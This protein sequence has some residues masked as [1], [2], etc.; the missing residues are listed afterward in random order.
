MT[1]SIVTSNF[2]ICAFLY[3]LFFSYFQG[4]LVFVNYGRYADF[5]KLEKDYKMNVSGKIVI[6]KYGKIFR[7]DKVSYNKGSYSL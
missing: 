7:G 1:S 2:N 6:A 4:E 5:E 3:I